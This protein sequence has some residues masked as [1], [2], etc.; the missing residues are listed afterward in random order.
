MQAPK[1]GCPLQPRLR[2]K[3][4]R[5]APPCP[6]GL[7][8]V[9]CREGPPTIV[10]L[11]HQQGR[12]HDLPLRG[13]DTDWGPHS[14]QLPQVQGTGGAPSGWGRL[15]GRARRPQLGEGRGRPHTT[16]Q[17]ASPTLST[18]TTDKSTHDRE[19]R[20]PPCYYHRQNLQRFSL[21]PSLLT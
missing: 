6:L 4:P 17:R 21:S 11:P 10:D 18:T 1:K 8:L 15:L 13:P 9:P 12:R 3:A 14:L 7:H 16:P 5:L 19:V 20:Q 2:I